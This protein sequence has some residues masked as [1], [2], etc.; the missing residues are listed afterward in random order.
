L[1]DTADFKIRP[2]NV[3]FSADAIGRPTIGAEVGGYY[4]NGLYGGSYISLSDMLGNHNIL[5]AGSIN[6]SFSDAQ[7]Y[8]GYSFLKTRL[9]MGAAFLQEPLYGY[10]GSCFQCAGLLPGR[11]N[12]VVNAD[13]FLRDLT[14]AVQGMAAYPF[15]TYQR[16][17]FGAIAA[18]RRLDR[19]I[20]GENL[21]RFE[22]L[23][24]TYKIRSEAY[25]QPSAALVF[26]NALFG[27]TGPIAG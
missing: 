3:R 27:W 7:I 10:L 19:I 11:E 9:N 26:D 14:R 24:E 5:L 16:F 2:Y 6:G 25:L 23:N 1:P 4:G 22:P 21:S 8:T 17:E 20:L 13:V 12:E 18:Y 15:N